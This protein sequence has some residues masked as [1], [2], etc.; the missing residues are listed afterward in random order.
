[1]GHLIAA[2]PTL[3]QKTDSSHGSPKTVGMVVTRSL[4]LKIESVDSPFKPFILNGTVA[5]SEDAMPEPILILRDIAQSFILDNVLPFSDITSC[6]SDVLVQGIELGLMK[7]PLH[8]VYLHSSVVSGCVN[9]AVCSQLPVKGVYFI[10][11]NDLAG[12]KVFS[13]PEV[14]EEPNT[15]V[16]SKKLV[17]EFPSVFSTCV[18]TRAQARKYTDAADISDTF[19]CE[20]SMAENITELEHAEDATFIMDTE[21]G[22]EDAA[23]NGQSPLTIW[24]GT[25]CCGPESR[26][27]FVSVL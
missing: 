1:M 13:L 20:D 9:V 21:C 25:A 24:K 3:R 27:L 5:I 2:C 10:L 17:Q 18:V 12:G 26:C 23:I 16:L 22:N 14:T 15:S 6:H 4:I 19:L 7:V 11:G 8:T